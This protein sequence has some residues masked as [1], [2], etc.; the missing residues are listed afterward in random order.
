MVP[1]SD[2]CHTAGLSVDW[3]TDKLYWITLHDHME[4]MDLSTGYRTEIPLPSIL[5]YH[6]N[7]VVDPFNGQA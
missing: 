1:Y 5:S 2:Y 6:S 3:L 4:V 7:L